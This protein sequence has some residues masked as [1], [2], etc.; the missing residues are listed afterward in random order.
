M[1]KRGERRHQ[2]DPPVVTVLIQLQYLFGRQRRVVLHIQ[3][4]LVH[5]IEGH[6]VR[7]PLQALQG[8]D[9]PSGDVEEEAPV[10]DVRLIL[11][12]R[13][14]QQAAAL[15]HDLPQRLNGPA[16]GSQAASAQTRAVLPDL[17]RILLIAQRAVH[18]QQDIPLAGSSPAD[19]GGQPR[20]RPELILQQAGIQQRPL[21]AGRVQHDH[22]VPLKHQLRVSFLHFL[23]NR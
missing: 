11:N 9:P 4:Q 7:Q 21:R 15:A 13:F 3:L 20:P 16:H 1:A 6:G 14:L 2:L 23:R 18:L 12:D 17:Q 5:L 10:L 8:Q 19:A 22:A